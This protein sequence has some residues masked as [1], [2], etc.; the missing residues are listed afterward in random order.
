MSF[1]QYARRYVFFP[2]IIVI[3]ISALTTLVFPH[4]AE[5][6][7]NVLHQFF[8]TTFGWLYIGA[9]ATFLIIC[10]FVMFSQFGYIRL[11]KDHERPVYGAISWFSMLFAAGMGIGLMYFS[12]AEPV[13]HYLNS[14]GQ[15]DATNAMNLTLLHWGLSAW[16]IYSLL[17][18][19]LAYFSYRHD[20]PLLPRAAL[21]PL[22]KERIYGIPGHLIDIFAVISTVFGVATSLGLG[23]AQINA[24]LSFLWAAPEG[25]WMQLT[26]IVVIIGIACISVALGLDSGIKRLSN[27]NM[28]LACL[29]MSFIL[30]TGPTIFLLEA[31]VNNIGTY[32]SSLPEQMFHTAAYENNDWIENNTLFFWGWWIAWSPFVSMFI[33]RVSRGRTL[34]QFLGGVLMIPTGFIIIWMSIFGNSAIALVQ[35]GSNDQLGQTSLNSPSTALFAYLQ[36]F[37]FT[38]IVSVIAILLV[39]IYFITSADSGALVV[40][41]I[42]NGNRQS[43]AL[44]R[45]TW[46]LLIGL[47]AFALLFAGGKQALNALQTATIASAFPFL[48]ILLAICVALLKSLYQEYQTKQYSDDDSI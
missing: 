13:Q 45:I 27:L 19:A 15:P 8:L 16:S 40:N 44:Q 31:M 37:P 24:G 7:F 34:R 35:S 48:L 30:I 1:I 20:L 12:V 23:T 25:I 22:L 32:L 33:A 11:G 4:L 38:T 10:L 29:L 46:C 17:A 2:A 14:P 5:S 26:I 47:V 18:L 6:F 9:V 42:A 21:Y 28:L 36:N 3:F 41:K 39:G 43:T